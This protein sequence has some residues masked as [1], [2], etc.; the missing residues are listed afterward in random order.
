M[1][2]Q[3]IG[4]I[5]VSSI[6]QNEQRQ[7]D[8][9][10]L[11]RVFTDKASGRD[12]ERPQLQAAVSYAREGDT[13]ICHSIDRLARNVGDM[14]R[15]VSE[16]NERGV[17]V[18]FVKENMVFQAESDDPRTTLMLT[19]LSAFAQFERALIRERQREGI[20]IAKAKGVY[21]GRKPT[22]NPE[23]R[24]EL[25]EKAAAGVPRAK[26][27]RDYGISRE[28]VYQYIR[29]IDQVPRDCAG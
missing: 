14:L 23:R 18:Q 3:R 27:A 11:D 19:L 24:A 13:F 6:D 8:C 26:L 1:K 20:A 7:L 9:I 29:S 17:T 15:L 21:K 2:T 5:R 22:L 25:C 12:I 16:L 10:E 4:Y 28:T